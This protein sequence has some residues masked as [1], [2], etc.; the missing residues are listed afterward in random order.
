MNTDNTKNSKADGTYEAKQT[1]TPAQAE[2]S[3]RITLSKQDDRSLTTEQQQEFEAQM[4]PVDLGRIRG[5]VKRT[6]NEHIEGSTGET[7]WYRHLRNYAS[8][9]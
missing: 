5:I 4:Q 1:D 6:L 2:V 8:I 7:R 3:V 9:I